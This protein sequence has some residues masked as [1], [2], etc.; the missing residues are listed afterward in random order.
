MIISVLFVIPQSMTSTNA[1]ESILLFESPIIS[2][3][4]N[5]Y[6]ISGDFEIRILHD[7]DLVRIMG[8]TVSGDPYYVYQQMIDD[9]PTLSGKIFINNNPVEIFHRSII[10]TPTI[11]ANESQKNKKNLLVLVDSSDSTQ[12]G[13]HFRLSI[14]AYDEDINP[15]P[16]LFSKTDGLLESIY[17]NAT[18]IDEND[19][20]LAIFEGVTDNSGEFEMEYYWK[21]TDIKGEYEIILDIDNG[22]YLETIKTNYLG[23]I[24]DAN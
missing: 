20:V 7:G 23:Y 3:P 2:T 15:H 11:E 12:Y 14:K 8:T 1:Q 4:S 18:M 6:E 19:N 24:A 9:I 21:F 16:E 13:E 17:V 5:D 22:N 10:D